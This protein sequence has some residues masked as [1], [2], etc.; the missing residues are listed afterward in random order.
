MLNYPLRKPMNKLILIDELTQGNFCIAAY[1]V[2]DEFKQPA[3]AVYVDPMEKPIILF[4]RIPNTTNIDIIVNE[5]PIKYMRSKRTNDIK[6]RR[7]YFKRFLVFMTAA[8]KKAK[9]TFFKNVEMKYL[10]DLEKLKL[11]RSI[12]VDE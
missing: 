5:E 12:Y 1:V 2:E 3:F 9:C 8:E 11:Y 4:K 6:I 7:Q 10:K